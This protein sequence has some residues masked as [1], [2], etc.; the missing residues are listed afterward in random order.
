MPA[1]TGRTYRQIMRD[2]VF[3]FIN[4][5]LFVLAAVLIAFRHY[6]D[7]LLSVGVVPPTP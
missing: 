3:N 7:A 6:L 2:N 1:T 5:I 4:N